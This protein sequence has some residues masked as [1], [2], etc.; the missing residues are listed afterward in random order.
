MYQM[1]IEMK[2]RRK[3]HQS[4]IG[5]PLLIVVMVRQI[6]LKIGYLFNNV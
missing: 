4:A 2:W 6:K 5:N 1:D 3:I